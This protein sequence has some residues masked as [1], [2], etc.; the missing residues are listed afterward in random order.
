MATRPDQ[1]IQQD[2][3]PDTGK[4]TTAVITG[5]H[6]FDVVGFHVFLSIEKVPF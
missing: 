4:V 1:M 5:S 6:P 3:F 2:P